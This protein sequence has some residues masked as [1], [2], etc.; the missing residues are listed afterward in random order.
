[1]V[2]LKFKMAASTKP[3]N[4]IFNSIIMFQDPEN[5]GIDTNIMQL[6]LP[7]IELLFTKTI[8]DGGNFEIQDGCLNQTIQSYY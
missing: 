8:L 1:M 6:W 4:I 5:L 7:Q 3:S 2:I